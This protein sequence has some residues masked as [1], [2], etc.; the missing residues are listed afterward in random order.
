MSEG[1]AWRIT[2]AGCV[3]AVCLAAIICCWMIGSA[4]RVSRY[5][6]RQAGG[7]EPLP[8]FYRFDRETGQIE[9]LPP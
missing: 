7:T 3:A 6:V 2:V 1:R 9:K 4:Y 5:E 8:G